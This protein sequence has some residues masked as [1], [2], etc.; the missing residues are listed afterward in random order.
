[1]KKVYYKEIS[2]KIV[3]IIKKN[4]LA[5]VYLLNDGKIFKKFCPEWI[6]FS[7]R[8]FSNMESRILDADK[9][10]NNSNLLLPSQIVYCLDGNQEFFVGYIMEKLNSISLDSFIDS[11]MMEKH[12]NLKIFN[13]IYINLMNIIKKY[14]SIVFPD[15][16]SKDNI[17]IDPKTFNIQLIDYDGF[18]VFNKSSGV[19][20]DM[21]SLDRTNW[22]NSKYVYMNCNFLY[23]KNLDIRSL[24]MLYFY[25][26]FNINLFSVRTY[27][28]INDELVRA[29]LSF[30]Q[31]FNLINLD[32]EDIMQAVWLLFQMDKDMPNEYL[33]INVLKGLEEKYFLEKFYSEYGSSVNGGKSFCRRL[34]LK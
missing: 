11:F 15:L 10:S 17:F 25:Y 5:T 32:N 12:L 31:L 9:F 29:K 22:E 16:C 34:V 23:T 6:E 8:K 13:D 3:K 4:K 7:C 2:N 19:I 24:I 28:N 27:I 20:S 21:I 1:M 30:D 33:D 14:D 26:T 18:Q